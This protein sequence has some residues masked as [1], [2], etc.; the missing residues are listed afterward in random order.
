[1]LSLAPG[2][3]MTYYKY[4][5]LKPFDVQGGSAMPYFGQVGG[6]IQYY[7]GGMPRNIRWLIDNSYL[8]ELK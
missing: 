2:T 1:M 8:I 3:D 7:T 5:V 4:G 6:G